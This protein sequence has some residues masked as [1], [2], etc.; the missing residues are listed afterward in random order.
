MKRIKVFIVLMI[1]GS[2]FVF[3]QETKEIGKKEEKEEKVISPIGKGELYTLGRGD[4]IEII[5]RNQPE[6][7]GK[8]VIG[9]DG[10]IQYRF[11][12]DIKAEGLTKEEL[13]KKLL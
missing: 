8:F 4:V 3:S 1:V 2:L 13:K 9:P 10:N 6:F 12:G 11:V 7:S 5:V